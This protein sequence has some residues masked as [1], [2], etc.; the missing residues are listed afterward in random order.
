MSNRKSYAYA[1]SDCS[2][3]SSLLRSAL[4]NDAQDR[5]PLLD[6][7]DLIGLV[8]WSLPVDATER[9]ALGEARSQAEKQELLGA[10]DCADA[11]IESVRKRL[12]ALE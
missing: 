6:V 5:G 1:T 9:S 3:L 8:E 4:E 12:G 10:L 11:V 2:K 7:V